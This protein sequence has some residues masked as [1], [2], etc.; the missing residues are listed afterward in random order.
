[1]ECTIL[2]EIPND[3]VKI[4]WPLEASYQLEEHESL[5][6]VDEHENKLYTS[7]WIEDP[8]YHEEVIVREM[9]TGKVID[10]KPGYLVTMPGGVRWLMT[11]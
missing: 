1:M 4:L 9:N 11:R 2:A 3:T 8:D 10:R 5:D 7:K 6:F